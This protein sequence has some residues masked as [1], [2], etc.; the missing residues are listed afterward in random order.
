MLLP[1]LA[2]HHHS[3]HR[4]CAMLN[5]V[6]SAGTRTPP[7]YLRRFGQN[8]ARVLPAV[9]NCCVIQCCGGSDRVTRC[10]LWR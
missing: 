4:S 6:C 1:T 10:D 9:E 8:W 3:Y 5:G 7:S 2:G